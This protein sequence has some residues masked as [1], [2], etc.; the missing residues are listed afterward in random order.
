MNRIIYISVIVFLYV[1]PSVAQQRLN[2]EM[3]QQPITKLFEFIEHQTGSR[4]Y[5]TPGE[6]DTLIVTIRT[7]GKEPLYILQEAL[8][9]T[10]Y[11][12]SKF[13]NVYFILKDKELFVPLF[14][15][16]YIT[17]TYQEESGEK[18]AR[19]S[20]LDNEPEDDA[21]SEQRIYEIGDA[22]N[23]K[24]GMVT[25][26]GNVTHIKTGEPLPGITLFIEKPLIGAVT[27]GFGYYSFQLPAGLQELNIRG[28]D[29][30]ETKRQLMLYSEG[31]LNIELEEKVVALSEVVIRGARENNIK[32]TS[33]GVEYLKMKDIKNIPTAFGETDVLR[34]VMSLPGVKAA[35]EISSGFNVRGGATDQNLIL[36]NGSTI[37]NP[38]HL[39]GIFSA[40]NPDVVSDMELYKSSIP[41]KY[42]GRISSVLEINSREGNKKEFQGSGSLGLLTS[43]LSIEGPVFKGKGSF[44]AGGRTTYSN[45]LLKMIPDN[46]GYNNGSAGFYDLNGTLVYTFNEHNK[47]FLNGYF[48]NDRFSFNEYEQYGYSNANASAKWWHVYHPKLVHLFTVGYDHYNHHIDNLEDTRS[49][50]TLGY[51]INQGYLKSDFSWF[52]SNHHTVNIGISSTLYHLSPGE[53]LPDGEES[54]VVEDRIQREKALESAIYMGDDWEITSHFSINA[55]LRYSIFQAIGPRDYH[56]Y[57]P[58]YLPSMSTLVST[59]SASGIFQTWHGPEFRFSARYAFSNDLSIKAGFNTM[60][61]YIHKISNTTIMSP[62]DTWKLSDANIRPQTGMQFSGGIFKNFPKIEASI[63]VYYKTMDDYLDYRP[64]AKLVMNHHVE[65]E[66]VNTTGKSYGVEL[67][68]KKTTG[69]LNGWISYAWSRTMLRQADK[70]ITLPVNDGNW[71]PSDFD[72]PQEIKFT[73]NY[74]ITQRYSVSLNLEY[75]TGR[76]ITLPE[77]KYSYA[78]GDYVFYAYRNQYRI[79][80]YFRMDLSFNIEPSHHLTLLT[81]SSISIGLY[82]LTGRKNVYSVYYITESGQLSGY[83]MSIFGTVIPFISYNIKF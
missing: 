31:K 71:F 73:G 29:V 32:S 37:F 19:K 66:L 55:G 44:I 51:K 64:G 1:A 63:E 25:L 60:R 28:V 8:Q 75:S 70:K 9:G 10:P 33:I 12:V 76:P 6:A 15:N 57:S 24:R 47:M 59:E 30:K 11:R 82:N 72:K 53:Y 52:P 58:D 49:A 2:V 79:P 22:K 62:T 65:T 42:G 16:Y 81:H 18:T 7:S 13:R 26:S 20:L 48:S 50:Y 17:E 21:I 77:A 69:K 45:W 80:D 14:D 38:T 56:L 68:L 27:D 54:L 4:I 3:E 5:C 46:S 67:L 35:G 36:F 39:F 40:F 78:G 43:R 61:Q 34:I 23:P 83:K 41:V 74:K